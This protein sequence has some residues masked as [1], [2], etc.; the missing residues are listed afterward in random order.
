[1]DHDVLHTA[2]Y[3]T[4]AT[5]NGQYVF[6][7]FGPATADANGDIN[8]EYIGGSFW[9]SFGNGAVSGAFAASRD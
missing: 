6:D 9:R 1:M 2:G 7:F 8:P 5:D 4:G 3:Q